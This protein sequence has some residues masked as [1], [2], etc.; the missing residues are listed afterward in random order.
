NK[1]IRNGAVAKREKAG[2]ASPRIFLFRSGEGTIR[3]AAE[4]A[5][6]D[7]CPRRSGCFAERSGKPTN[8]SCDGQTTTGGGSRIEAAGH[9]L[10]THGSRANNGIVCT[11]LYAPGFLGGAVNSFACTFFIFNLEDS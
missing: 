4:R 7:H 1:N 2:P 6:R 11:N 9:S 8:A 3:D 5:D 10:S